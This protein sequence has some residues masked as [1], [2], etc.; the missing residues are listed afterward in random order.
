MRG[1][2]KGTTR[3]TKRA[4]VEELVKRNFA[5]PEVDRVWVADTTYVATQEG[6]LYLAFILDA[7]S[8]R[9]VG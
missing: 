6:F 9:I 1:S 3:R 7:D 8:R 2:R 4:L 5:A